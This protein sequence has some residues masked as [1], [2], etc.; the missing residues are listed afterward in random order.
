MMILPTQNGFYGRSAPK[1]IKM[2]AFAAKRGTNTEK[3][4]AK[5]HFPWSGEPKTKAT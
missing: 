1:T 4:I 2:T 5:A 3:S